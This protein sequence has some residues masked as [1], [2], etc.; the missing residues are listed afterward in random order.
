M[1][2]A[3]VCAWDATSMTRCCACAA[4]WTERRRH[5]ARRP[6]DPLL[7]VDKYFRNSGWGLNLEGEHLKKQDLRG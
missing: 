6:T 3:S 1:S 4:A 2:T 5:G 7:G